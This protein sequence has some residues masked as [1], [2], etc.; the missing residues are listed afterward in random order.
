MYEVGRKTPSF[1]FGRNNRG[2][3]NHS[4]RTETVTVTSMLVTAAG[5]AVGLKHIFATRV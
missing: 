1:N 5:E 4:Q 3:Q 2:L